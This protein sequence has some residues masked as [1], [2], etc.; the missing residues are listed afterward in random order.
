MAQTASL[1][2]I[3]PTIA[4]AAWA[5]CAQVRSGRLEVSSRLAP[6]RCTEAAP[7]GSHA[8]SGGG[9]K[10]E[11]LRLRCNRHRAALWRRLPMPCQG[12]QGGGH[13]EDGVMQVK[14]ALICPG[15]H[16]ESRLPSLHEPNRWPHPAARI[17]SNSRML[18]STDVPHPIAIGLGR[19]LG[20]DKQ[21][22]HDGTP[23]EADVSVR[24][25][26]AG[27]QTISRL[28]SA[29]PGLP[30]RGERKAAIGGRRGSGSHQLRRCFCFL[31]L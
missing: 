20:F 22:Q 24:R 6:H 16:R 30:P 19:P 21:L 13:G 23:W 27:T 18:A 14:Q 28:L 29:A 10:T 26:R 3:G 2:K 9:H 1:G 31:F 8:L 4:A 25:P 5:H 15:T 7:R 11:S 17:K 12:G